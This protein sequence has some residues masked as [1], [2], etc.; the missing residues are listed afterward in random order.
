MKIITFIIAAFISF[1]A[2]ADWHYGKINLLAIAYDGKTISVG[3]EGFTRSDCTCYPTWPNRYCLDRDRLSFDEEY[4]MLLAAKAKN[5]V[6]AIHI[7]EAT[8]V[9]KAMYEN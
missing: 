5:A 9:V 6:L 4:S 7:D 8:C 3:Q 1:S 2:A